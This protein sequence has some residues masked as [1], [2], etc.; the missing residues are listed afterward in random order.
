MGGCPRVDNLLDFL[1]DLWQVLEV[2][3]Q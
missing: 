3:A 1:L 2:V